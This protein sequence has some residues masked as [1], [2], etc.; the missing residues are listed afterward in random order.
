MCAGVDVP[1]SSGNT[2]EGCQWEV[3]ANEGWVPYWDSGVDRPMELTP[4]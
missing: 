1:P 3:Q 4:F 2:D